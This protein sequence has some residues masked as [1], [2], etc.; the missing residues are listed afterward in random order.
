MIGNADLGRLA[1][2]HIAKCL[3]LKGTLMGVV[4]TAGLSRGQHS[5]AWCLPKVLFSAALC[6]AVL[7]C[8]VLCRAAYLC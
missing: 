2:L 7:C 8:A 4:A 5:V 3:A 1:E 6:C